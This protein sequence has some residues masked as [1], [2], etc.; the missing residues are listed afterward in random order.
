MGAATAANQFVSG[1]ASG[2]MVLANQFS[3][4]ALI[5]G[6]SNVERFR[7]AVG[8][9]ATFTSTVQA[10]LAFR[11][12]AAV[13]YYADFAYSGSTYNLGTSETT[14][15]IDFK[16]A[17][18]GTFTTGGGFRFFTQAGGSTPVERVNI[19]SG[20][21]LNINGVVASTQIKLGILQT[22]NNHTAYLYVNNGSGNANVYSRVDAT[23]N[24]F[25][26]FDYNGT[27]V[28]SVS[29]NGTTTAYNITSDYRLKQ[30]FKSYNGL[31]LISAIK[32]YDY[33]WKSDKS[34]MYGVIAHELQEIIP[35]A[36][37]GQKDGE[38]M[39]G[40]DYSKIVPILIKSI[41]ELKQ[42]IDTLKNK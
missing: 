40:V 15:N 17:G 7:I 24:V 37:Q 20:G 11:Q 2:D 30:D 18:G 16:I 29:T 9:G 10:N 25:S 23:A 6:T 35:Y 4:G 32:T 13:G 22:Q 12:Y 38:Q 8:G 3:T 36:V 33:E 31:D 27:V 19:K 28:G 21:Q 34:R 1:T 14:D 39:Q 5:F 41:Q 26:Y 42:E